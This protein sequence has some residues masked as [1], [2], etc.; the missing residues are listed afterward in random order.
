MLLWTITFQGSIGQIPMFHAQLTKSVLLEGVSGWRQLMCPAHLLLCCPVKAEK[1]HEVFPPVR[2][3]RRG[4]LFFLK[5]P[6]GFHTAHWRL[7]PLSCCSPA[8]LLVIPS[9][10]LG[11]R[12]LTHSFPFLTPDFLI[13]IPDFSVP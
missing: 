6:L 3:G 1:C 2:Q 4:C 10:S 12:L 5:K 7:F 11:I 9:H 13:S 8:D